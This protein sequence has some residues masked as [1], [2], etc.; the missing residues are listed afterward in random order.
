MPEQDI[1]KG[2][3]PP[4]PDIESEKELHLYNWLPGR[5]VIKTALAI[6]L[7]LLIDYLRG[8]DD[9]ILSAIAAIICMKPTI[10]TSFI[11]AKERLIATMVGG[12]CGLVMLY[13][14]EWLKFEQPSIPYYALISL[15]LL[16]MMYILVLLNQQDTITLSTIIVLVMGISPRKDITPLVYTAYRMVET[17]IGIAISIGVNALPFLKNI[18][19]EH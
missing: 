13:V 6:F 16:L 5:R 1:K 8:N 17:S 3:K 10:K 7:C 14:T 2:M 19:T 15:F 18:R 4:L 9:T 12:L 11:A